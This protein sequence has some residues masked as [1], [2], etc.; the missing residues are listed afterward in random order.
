MNDILLIIPAFN[1]EGNIVR[2]VDDLVNNHKELDYVIINDGSTDHTSEICH[3]HG[4]NII[5]HPENMGLAAAFHTGMEYAFDKGYKYAVQFDGDG[6]HRAEFVI[7]MRE[8]ADEGYDIV[9]ASRFVNSKKKLTMRMI[10]SNMIEQAIKAKTGIIIN[11]PTSGM[12]LYNRRMIER[13]AGGLNLPPEPSTLVYL[14]KNDNAKV[15]EI[16]ATMDERISGESYLNPAKAA[17]YMGK[18]LWTILFK[19]T[20]NYS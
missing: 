16:P 8:K 9:I 7:P 6:Q 11:D 5:D 10:G 15:A 2:V 14:I 4:Y 1:E 12:R 18:V 17:E 20:K 13:F 19:N 3:S